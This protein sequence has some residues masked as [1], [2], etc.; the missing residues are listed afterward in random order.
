MQNVPDHIMVDAVSCFAFAGIESGDSADMIRSD[1]LGCVQNPPTLDAMLALQAAWEAIR[2]ANQTTVLQAAYIT[3]NPNPVGSKD[4]LD[5][6]PGALEYHAV[7]TRYHDMFRTLVRS[8]G[9]YDLFVFNLRGDCVY[10]VSKEIDFATNFVSGQYNASGLGKTY[11]AAVAAPDAVH[12]ADFAP[13]EP[14]HGELASFICTGVADM[15]GTPVGVICIQTIRPRQLCLEPTNASC[16]LRAEL[17][18]GPHDAV[19]LGYHG[20]AA[21]GVHHRQPEPGRLEGQARPGAGSAGVP[22]GAYA[23]P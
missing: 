23:V 20:G 21:G 19:R 1:L 11:C 17:E 16:S 7:H 10:T 5:R 15:L 22:R 9:Y 2:P 13:Y 18:L 12:V 8:K 4:K 3:D 6:A 14:S